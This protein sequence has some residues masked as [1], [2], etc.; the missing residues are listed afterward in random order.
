M[1]AVAADPFLV[2]MFRY[3]VTVGDLGMSAVKGRV[4]ARDLQ[5]IGLGGT[6]RPD[7]Q[8]VVRLVQRR[9]RDQDLQLGEHGVIDGHM[10]V[11]VGTAMNDT[12]SDGD[13]KSPTVAS[14]QPASQMAECRLRIRQIG[15]GKGFV[16]DDFP[17]RIPG[18]QPG[19]AADPLDLSLQVP[20]EGIAFAFISDIEELKLDARRAG[21][22]D[23]DGIRHRVILLS[24]FQ[25]GCDGRR[26]RPPHRTPCASSRCRPGWS[27]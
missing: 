21:I 18:D 17:P 20:V 22:D 15:G 13:R 10:R 23:E 6:D 1:E 7:R 9:Q 11:V 14:P 8:K 16:G 24:G 19:M 2:K 5:D 3:G 26:G 12:V 4:E 27:G 25:G